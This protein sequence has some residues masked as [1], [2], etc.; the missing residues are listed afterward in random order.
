[1]RQSF[2]NT[3]SG[4]ALKKQF[5][6]YTTSE[7]LCSKNILRREFRVYIRHTNFERMKFIL[8]LFDFRSTKIREFGMHTI[9]ENT[10]DDIN[11]VRIHT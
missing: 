4:D 9:F 10:F 8:E 7:L 3:L 5:A 2:P 1:M 6:E 11:P